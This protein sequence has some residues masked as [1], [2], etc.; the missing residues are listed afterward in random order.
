MYKNY[1]LLID[2]QCR[3]PG[4]AGTIDIVDTATGVTIG[5]SPAASVADVEEAIAAAGRGLKIWRATQVWARAN[6]NDYGLAADVFTRNPARM[7]EAPFGGIK[8]SGMGREGGSE[9][10]LDYMNVKLT[11]AVV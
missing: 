11:Q 10:I 3:S 8:S 2:G 7:R 9:G 5:N 6:G 1:G 4:G